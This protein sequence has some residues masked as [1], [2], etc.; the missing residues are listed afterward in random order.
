[1]GGTYQLDVV[2]FLLLECLDGLLSIQLQ[3]EGQ[4]LQSLVLALHADLCLH[5]EMETTLSIRTE[6]GKGWGRDTKENHP[7]QNIF[8]SKELPDTWLMGTMA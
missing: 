5:L 8:S 4:A 2:D 1:M 6:T 7:Q 3:R